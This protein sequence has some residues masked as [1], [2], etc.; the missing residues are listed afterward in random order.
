MTPADYWNN[1][2]VREVERESIRSFVFSCRGQLDR[3]VLDYG[4]GQ[5]PYREIVEAAGGTYVPYDRE[6]FPANVSG[7]NVGEDAPLAA[8]RGFYDAILCNQVVQYVPDVYG[9][10]RAFRTALHRGGHLVLTYP[11][12]WAEVE[13][14]DLHRFTRNGMDSLLARAGF[15]VERHEERAGIDLGGFHLALG[16]GAVARA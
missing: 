11:T 9:L 8:S 2:T 3:R 6:R 13:L 12:N 1:D 15:A 10:L 5:Q 16:Y 7:E 4:C 14:A